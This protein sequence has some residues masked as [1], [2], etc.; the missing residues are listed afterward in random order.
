MKNFFGILGGIL[1]VVVILTMLA[2][3]KIVYKNSKNVSAEKVDFSDKLLIKKTEDGI[4]HLSST[5]DDKLE[6][7]IPYSSLE[8]CLKSGGTE[9][10]K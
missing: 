10:N 4:C 3:P 5:D 9:E 6:K 8:S 2:I 7:F 1:F